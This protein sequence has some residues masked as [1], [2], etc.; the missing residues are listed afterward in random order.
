MYVVFDVLHSVAFPDVVEV[1]C[2]GGMCTHVL[3]ETLLGFQV[4]TTSEAR[5]VSLLV[6][7]RATYNVRLREILD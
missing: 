6:R 4:L 1:A 7:C 3:N 5:H 2:F